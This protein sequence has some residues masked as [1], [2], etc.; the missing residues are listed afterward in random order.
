MRPDL[1]V[2]VD[3]DNI[4]PKMIPEIIEYLLPNW[5]LTVRKAFGA[6][7]AQKQTILRETGFEPVEVLPNTLRGKNVTDIALVSAMLPELFFRR[8]HGF[9]VATGDSDFT[10]PVLQIRSLGIPIMVFGPKTTP[11]CL[12]AACSR[13]YE[14]S[15]HPVDAGNQQCTAPPRMYGFDADRLRS[16]V[17]M[18]FR[19]FA[20]SN[21][22]LTVMRFGHYLKRRDPQL[23]GKRYGAKS[24][25]TLLRR[26]GGFQLTEIKNNDGVLV[27]YALAFASHQKAIDKPYREGVEVPRLMVMPHP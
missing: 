5:N 13:F 18:L 23:T 4:S 17:T 8:V 14:L 21:R 19:D 11:L 7:L 10:E 25:T 26:L 9:A 22:D 16:R 6:E 2:L 27:D 15:M 1:A 20:A 3:A 24:I 12:R